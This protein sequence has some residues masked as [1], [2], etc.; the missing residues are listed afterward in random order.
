MISLAV[1]RCL[2]LEKTVVEGGG[3]VGQAPGSVH[4][5]VCARKCVC[6]R[7]CAR[8]RARVCV[9]VNACACACACACVFACVCACVRAT[10]LLR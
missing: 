1:L 9:S 7:M 3:V 2:E 4:V 10:P 5:C 6:V 8:V